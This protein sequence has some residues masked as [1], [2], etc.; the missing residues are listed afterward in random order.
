M[1][2]AHL[3]FPEYIIVFHFNHY[4][5]CQ[6][7]LQTYKTVQN[8]AARLVFRANRREHTIPLLREQHRLQA[9]QLCEHIKFKLVSKHETTSP[10]IQNPLKPHNY[11]DCSILLRSHADENLL[12]QNRT[13]TTYGDNVF[14][15]AVPALSNK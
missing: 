8:E 4:I 2:Y 13:H 15:Y 10:F 6:R 5:N 3:L 12:A 1:I 7:Q 14:C 9:C 11:S